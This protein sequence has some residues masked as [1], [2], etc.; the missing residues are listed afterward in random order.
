M[1]AGLAA[2]IGS[3]LPWATVSAP[4]V[5]TQSASG[6]DGSDGWVTAGIGLLLVAYGAISLRNQRTN[7]SVPI[8]AVVGTVALLALCV[9]KLIDL[10]IKIRDFRAG[11]AASV[12]D[13]NFGI[14]KALS[15]ATQ[16]KVGVGLWLILFASAIGVV[17]TGMLLGKRANE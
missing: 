16:I 2:V 10:E 13:D 3:F 8:V 12:S 11:L 5:G 9:W 4:I 1:G 7:L 17:S 6:V 14:G 15:D